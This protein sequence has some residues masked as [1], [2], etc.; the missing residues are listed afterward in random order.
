M[1]LVSGRWT[2]VPDC[3]GV[4][5]AENDGAAVVV[6]Q[7]SVENIVAHHRE[8]AIRIACIDA[9]SVGLRFK[10]VNSVLDVRKNRHDDA[11]SRALQISKA[12]DGL[13]ARRVGI[14][15]SSLTRRQNAA[16][17]GPVNTR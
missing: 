14:L 8:V 12:L 9:G 15:A 11:A 1:S 13:S 2:V 6:V 10:L 7:R 5:G 3:G 17:S 16:S 4:P